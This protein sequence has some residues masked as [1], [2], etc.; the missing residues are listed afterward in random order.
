MIDKLYICRCNSFDPYYNLA[1]EQHLSHILPSNSCILYLWQND[2]SIIIGRNQNPWSEC[3]ISQ[4]R[5]DHIPVVRRLSG[6]GAVYHDLGNLNYTFITNTSDYDPKKQLSVI[7]QACAQLGIHASVSGRNDI[8]AAN[9]KFSGNAFQHC[10]GHT[11]HHGTILIHTDLLKM[12][13]Y[14]TPSAAKLQAKGIPSVRSR[15]LNLSELCPALT[16]SSM[17]GKILLSFEEIYGYKSV[18]L[19][20]QD[21]DDQMIRNKAEELRSNQWIYQSTLPFNLTM[22]G[23]FSWGNVQLLLQIEN[24]AIRHI[25]LY[26]DALAHNFPAI[27]KETLLN[28]PFTAESIKKAIQ[29]SQIPPLIQADLCHMISQQDF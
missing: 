4:V 24:A 5:A 16:P 14:L 10:D 12:T 8:L 17:A 7:V 1:T 26:T 27:L 21:L 28:C 13:E 20:L 23:S 25:T 22:E 29:S 11:L 19:A 2:R 18:D 9:R 6:G 3:S 15:V